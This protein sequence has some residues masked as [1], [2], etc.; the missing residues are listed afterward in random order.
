MTDSHTT[1]ASCVDHGREVL[2]TRARELVLVVPAG[3]PASLLEP[4]SQQHCD[5]TVTP[6]HLRIAQFV[7]LTNSDAS[8]LLQLRN[9]PP[10]AEIVGAVA[11]GSM[12]ANVA[13]SISATCSVGIIELD[14]DITLPPGWNLVAQRIAAFEQGVE[15]RAESFTLDALPEAATWYVLP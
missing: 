14:V 9:R 4:P 12:L 8:L 11:Y 15:E 7:Y 10:D 13:G 1:G 2:M 3:I 5:A 6:E